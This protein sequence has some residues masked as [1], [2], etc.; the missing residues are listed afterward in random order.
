MEFGEC[1]NDELAV[2]SVMIVNIWII[3]SRLAFHGFSLTNNGGAVRVSM[4]NPEIERMKV[5][6]RKNCAYLIYK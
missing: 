3:N 6:R 5:L 4:M 1:I 2:A